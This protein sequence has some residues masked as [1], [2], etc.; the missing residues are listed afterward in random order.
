MDFVMKGK[1]YDAIVIGA[2]PAGT[3]AARQ[4]ALKGLDTILI[5][6]KEFPR[7][8]PCAGGVSQWALSNLDCEVPEEIIER[9][10]FGGRL[11]FKGSSVE[12]RKP[13]RVG[14]IVSRRA[15]DDFLL[16]RARQAGAKVCLPTEARDFRTKPDSVEI[17]TNKGL[18]RGQCIVIAEGAMGG[19]ARTIRGP[20]GQNG[21][22]VAVVTEVESSEDEIVQR[23][24]GQIQ[25]YF[26]VAHRG[27]GWIFPHKGYYSIG[28]GGISGRATNPVDVLKAFLRRHGF[29][30]SQR[31]RG[32]FLP[33]GGIRRKVVGHRTILVGDAAGFVDSFTGEGIGYAIL[34][35]RLAAETISEAL[36]QGSPSRIDLS[37][38]QEKCDS[39][40]GARLRQA[41][42][43]TRVLHS[44]P[45]VFLR[46]LATHHDVADKLLDVGLWKI[47]YRQFLIWLLVRTPRYLLQ[48]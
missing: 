23:T 31:L 34:S 13:H 20:Y 28:I 41:Y 47:S 5:E 37:A 30:R 45:G 40:F 36:D 48:G 9:E 11:F 27:Y 24:Q 26:D 3:T 19:L 14:I 39:H 12:A 18:F 46:T 15:F 7:Y 44:L 22:A 29:G 8:K 35:G 38:F 32:H 25:I 1:L 43:M 17:A 6:K 33:V 4:C 42:Q 16:Q 21:R 10:L 2:G